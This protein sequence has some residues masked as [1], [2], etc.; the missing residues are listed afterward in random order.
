MSSSNPSD[1]KL[2]KKI[3]SDSDIEFS[4]WA[5]PDVT[6]A[7]D[8]SISNVFGRSNHQQPKPTT[9]ESV[10]P[11]T[12]A[13]IESIRA[14]AEEEGFTEGQQRGYEQGLEKG[15]LQ[16]LEQG[17]TEGLAQGHEQGLES[18]LAQ[19]KT[20]LSRFE[21]LLTQFETPLQLLDGDIELS[22]MTLSMTLAKSVIG[23]EL[24]THPEQILS[25]LR[26]GIE[27]LPIKDQP[28]TIRL[29]PDDAVL[30]EQLYTSAQLTRSKWELEIDPSLSL[31]D[32]VLSSHRSLVDLTLASR[33]DAVFEPLRDQHAHLTDKQRQLQETIAAENTAKQLAPSEIVEPEF[34]VESELD[35]QTVDSISQQAEDIQPASTNNHSDTGSDAKSPTSTTE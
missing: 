30:V 6:E 4:H 9:V 5:L 25:A 32:C 18:G 11:P 31:G 13:E 1:N 14:Q 26:L 20:L 16:G 22:L 8:D 23:H 27:S 17:H 15:R 3:V 10:A 35:S 34:N 24:K 28:V 19:A 12:M 2:S 21:A 7:E 33:I 29:H